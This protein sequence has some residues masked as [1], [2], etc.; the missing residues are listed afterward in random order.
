MDMMRG[1]DLAVIGI[2]AAGLLTV[3][4]PVNALLLYIYFRSKTL[5]GKF[6]LAAAITI[7]LLVYLA[8]ICALVYDLRIA[9]VIPYLALDNPSVFIAFLSP[10]TVCYIPIVIAKKR[11]LI[12]EA[13]PKKRG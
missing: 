4:A 3:H 7:S 10:V 11:K 1:M 5:L 8:L 2:L 12:G 13:L 9:L 6:M